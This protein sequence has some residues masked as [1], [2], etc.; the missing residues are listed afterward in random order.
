M[1]NPYIKFARTICIQVN[2]S[3]GSVEMLYFK[4]NAQD[5]IDR[6]QRQGYNINDILI[7]TVILITTT[8]TILITGIPP[9]KSPIFRQLNKMEQLDY[10]TRAAMWERDPGTILHEMQS[11]TNLTGGTVC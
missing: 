8:I 11:A 9:G 7:T 10:S 6:F 1:L 3:P 5:L 2:Y 4:P